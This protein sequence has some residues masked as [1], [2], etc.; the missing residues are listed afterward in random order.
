LDD[1]RITSGIDLVREEGIFVIV[2]KSYFWYRAVDEDDDD[3]SE[4]GNDIE[5]GHD[6]KGCPRSPA[7]KQESSQ[8]RQ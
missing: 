4:K 5:E 6:I 8:F 7:I 1:R 3:C 2:G